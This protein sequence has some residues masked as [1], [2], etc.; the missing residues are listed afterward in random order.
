MSNFN[1]EQKVLEEVVYKII[2]K[3]EFYIFEDVGGYT[4][5]RDYGT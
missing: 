1:K 2:G 3:S 4:G 5:I